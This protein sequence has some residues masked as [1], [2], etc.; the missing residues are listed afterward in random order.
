[1]SL[2]H[3]TEVTQE[4]NRHRLKAQ[5]VNCGEENSPASPAVIRTGNLSVESLVLEQQAIPASDGSIKFTF[6]ST[7]HT[8]KKE[9]S[10]E[11]LMLRHKTVVA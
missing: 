9:L 6:T 11:M 2:L 7:H 8:A 1:M 10:E 5:K 3:A 4:W